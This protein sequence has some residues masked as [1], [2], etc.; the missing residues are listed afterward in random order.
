MAGFFFFSFQI[1]D[2][3]QRRLNRTSPSSEEDPSKENT[4]KRATEGE[5]E[6]NCLH[7]NKSFQ[8]IGSVVHRLDDF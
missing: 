8:F 7:I 1:S 3:N 4:Q 2:F 5:L 6:V